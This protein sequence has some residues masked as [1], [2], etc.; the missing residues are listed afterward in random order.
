MAA[1]FVA[2]N[3]VVFLHA[4]L[5]VEGSGVRLNGWP[6]VSKEVVPIRIFDWRTMF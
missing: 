2:C 5:D 1:K 3:V 6:N 4:D